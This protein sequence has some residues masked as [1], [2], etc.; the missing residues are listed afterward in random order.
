MPLQKFKK[1]NLTGSYYNP[2][3]RNLGLTF[4]YFRFI[5]GFMTRLKP[6]CEENA[7]FLDYVRVSYLER[8]KQALPKSVL[9]KSWPHSPAALEEVRQADFQPSG[10]RQLHQ[11]VK[12]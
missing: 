5:L 2:M 1:Q 6:R 7:H 12:S 9:D 10:S 8:C 3:I 4:L 11:C